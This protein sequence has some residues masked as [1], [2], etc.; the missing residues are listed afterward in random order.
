[1]VLRDEVEW[2]GVERAGHDSKHTTQRQRGHNVWKQADQTGSQT[3][4]KVA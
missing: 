3:K 2:D 4:H 1:M